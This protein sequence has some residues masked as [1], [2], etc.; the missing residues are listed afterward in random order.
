[1]VVMALLSC[2]LASFGVKLQLVNLLKYI[3]RFDRL[4]YSLSF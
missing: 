2:V 1:M 3:A 4:A